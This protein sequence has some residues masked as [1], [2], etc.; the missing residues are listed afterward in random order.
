MDYNSM[1]KAVLNALNISRI[2]GI[3][4][5][6][7]DGGTELITTTPLTGVSYR[8]IVIREAT[9]ITSATGTMDGSLTLVNFVTNW[10]VGGV[11]LN[12]GEIWRGSK[13]QVITSITLGS[14]SAI[15]LL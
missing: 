7:A 15:G 2:P 9:V 8:A 11:T 5:V 14:G 1:F 3:S 12:Q 13:G 10:K 6:S 4:L